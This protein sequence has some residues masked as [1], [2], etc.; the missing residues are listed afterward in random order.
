M[1]LLWLHVAAGEKSL[2]VVSL[3][4]DRFE[5]AR[6]SKLSCQGVAE[7]QHGPLRSLQEL[8]D[9]AR[10]L[11][12]MRIAKNPDW[13]RHLHDRDGDDL[14]AEFNSNIEDELMRSPMMGRD[15]DTQ[16]VMPIL[17]SFSPA[18]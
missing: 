5:Q 10:E 14:T 4:S 16:R 17:A 8:D 13:I 6:D 2:Q 15:P 18:G 7:G 12:T 3:V 9:A 1:A 11:A